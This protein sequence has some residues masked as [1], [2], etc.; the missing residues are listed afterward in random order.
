ML[1]GIVNNIFTLLLK[2]TS[3]T[4]GLRLFLLQKFLIEMAHKT[5]TKPAS[6]Y[7][8]QSFPELPAVVL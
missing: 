4:P 3:G 7:H 8:S 2:K 5:P 1:F 6:L